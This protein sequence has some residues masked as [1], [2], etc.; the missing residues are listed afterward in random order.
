MKHNYVRLSIVLCFFFLVGGRLGHRGTTVLEYPHFTQNNE[1][2][3][4]LKPGLP[5]TGLQSRRP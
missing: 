4:A 2:I 5:H 3:L 1:S